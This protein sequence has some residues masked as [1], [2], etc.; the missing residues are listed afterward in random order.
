MSTPATRI[1][2]V[3]DEPN[4]VI[5]IEFLMK[6]EG[7][8]TRT[9]YNGTEALEAAAEFRPQ[10]L[11]LDVMMPGMDGFEVA[12]QIRE[13]P[14]MDG[15]KMVFL[16]AKGTQRDKAAGYASGAEYYLVKPFDND[17]LVQTITEIITYG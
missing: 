8:I 6:R 16:T 9:A 1:L 17:E 3:D 15:V 2:I 7:H 11:I 12:R 5:A 14:D 13:N 4:I 10:L